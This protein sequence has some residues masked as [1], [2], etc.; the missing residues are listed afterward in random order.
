VRAAAQVL[1][2][3]DG[4]RHEEVGVSYTAADLMK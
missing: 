1:Q 4:C 3:L 2:Y